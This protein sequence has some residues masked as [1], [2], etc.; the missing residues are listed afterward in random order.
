MIVG[1]MLY[2]LKNSELTF[3]AF[4]DL[5]DEQE[6]RMIYLPGFEYLKIHQQNIIKY[7]NTNVPDLV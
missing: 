2:H 7:L 6:L 4:I 3:W 5:M 1:V